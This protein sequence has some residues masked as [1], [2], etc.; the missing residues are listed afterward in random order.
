[1]KK[2]VFALLFLFATSGRAAEMSASVALGFFSAPVAYLQDE[3]NTGSN[4]PL[5]GIIA[6]GGD[7]EYHL[8]K[9]LALG[10]YLRYHGTGDDVGPNTEASFSNL[11]LG[12]MAKG[13]LN[14]RNW[15]FYYGA[16]FGITST[17]YEVEAGTTTTETDPGMTLGPVLVIGGLYPIND[18][19][20]I[21][22]ENMRIYALGEDTNGEVVSDW[23]IKGKFN[24]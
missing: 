17:H 21:G 9:D 18:K 10:A 12:A 19:F 1:M 24:F 16:G 8:D 7:F 23:T 15:A 20:S 5:S 22:I 13:Y 4:I 3:P 6:I 14:S 11:A 2:L